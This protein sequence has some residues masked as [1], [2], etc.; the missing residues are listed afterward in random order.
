MGVHAPAQGGVLEEIHDLEI[1]PGALRMLVHLPDKA[2]RGCPLVVVLH[3]CGQTAAGYAANAG[4]VELADRHGFALLCPEQTRSN[5]PNLCFNWFSPPDVA[6]D[7]GEAASIY[8]MVQ[9]VIRDHGIDPASVFITGLSAGGAMAAAM[10]AIYPEV[11]QGGAI[12]AG[13]PYGAARDVGQALAAMRNTPP[14]SGRV[15]GDKVRRAA[16]EP[17]RWPRVSIWHGDADT[18]VAPATAD[19][20]VNQWTDLHQASAV[21]DVKTGSTRHRRQV[22]KDAAGQP[23]VELNRI[24]GMAHGTPITATGPE[25]CGSAGPWVLDV[26]VSSSAMIAGGWGVLDRAAPHHASRPSQAQPAKPT[27]ARPTL[28]W[29][30]PAR[31]DVGGVIA[32]ALK[33]AGLLR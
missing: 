33:T 25:A 18:T 17:R 23:V 26:G 1:N 8:Q 7:T 13:L 19:A 12:I 4:W 16:P 20:L 24:A 3:G 21:S 14:L 30:R 9:R 22:W 2:A 27:A 10:L 29:S 5:N 28:A 31:V 11:F 6:R 15:W 32:R